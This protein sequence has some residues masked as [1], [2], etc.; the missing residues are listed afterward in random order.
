VKWLGLDGKIS[1]LK[2]GTPHPL[3]AELVEKLLNSVEEVLVVEELEPFV[4]NHVKVIA[5]EN[6]TPV[7]IH[8]KDLIPLIGELSTRKVTEAITQ[9]TKSKSPVDFS[10]IDKTEQEAAALLPFRPPI[11]C[12]GCPHRGTQYAIKTAARRVA[13]DYGKDVEAIF[14]GDITCAALAY[15]P[16]LEIPDLL[17]CM[18]GGFGMSNGIAHAVKAPIVAQLGDSTFFH[19]GIPPLVNAVYNK[20][21]ITMVVM[22]NSATAMTGFQPHPGT[23]STAVGDETVQL[24]PEEIAKACGVK[25]VEVI[26]PFDLKNATATL[27]KA[28]RFEGPSLVVSRRICTIVGEREKRKRGEETIL[29][30]I[31]QDKCDVKCDA[32]IKLL[33]CPSI[34]KEDGRTAIDSATCTGCGVC[35]QICPR[36]AIIIKE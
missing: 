16:P 19:S 20:A 30:Y 12:A 10:Q 18:G 24:K 7:K 29:Y 11:L 26:D 5:Q 22:D 17:I 15:I 1:I 23:G 32:C 13:R 28:I 25:F 9:L 3:P 35:A 8:G 2:I 21:N 27:E 6:N 14:P 4:E 31:D 36:N 33:G 34:V